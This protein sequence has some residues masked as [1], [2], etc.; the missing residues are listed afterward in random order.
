MF[1][2][3]ILY[4]GL[5]YTRAKRRTQFISFITFTSVLGIALGVTALI[6]VL[7]VMN[8]FEAELRERIL[9]MTAHSTISGRYGQLDDWQSLAKRVNTMPHVEGSAP[10]IQ[11]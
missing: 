6:T 9:G 3:L 11:G 7:S 1:K 10:F 5:R 4:I 8:G 2:P